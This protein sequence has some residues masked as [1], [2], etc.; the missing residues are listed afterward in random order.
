M[1]KTL[2]TLT[3]LLFSSGFALA[4]GPTPATKPGAN[5]PT[6]AMDSAVPEMKSDTKDQQP[7][8]KA[9]GDAVPPMKAGDKAAPS[10]MPGMSAADAFD[11]RWKVKDTAGQDFEIM[12][13]TDGTAKA[14]R[15]EGMT[16]T[17][18]NDG[19]AAVITWD[20]GW[21]TKISKDGDKYTKTAFK[22]GEADSGK[23]ANSSAAEKV[24]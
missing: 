14:T 9:V 19:G 1:K 20:T 15:G 4:Q 22:K 12:L 23:P 6:K 8:T 13:A 2:L 11:G 5:A 24:K 7:P 18:K 16:G 10:D 21:V 3:C 17:W